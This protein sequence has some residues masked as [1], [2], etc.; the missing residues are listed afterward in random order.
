[1]AES[2]PEGAESVV[3]G[4]AVVKVD[5]KWR[6]KHHLIAEAQLGRPLEPNERVSF[7]DKNRM[8]LDPENIEVK[9]KQST[10]RWKRLRLLRRRILD[11]DAKLLELKAEYQQ[12]LDSAPEKEEEQIERSPQ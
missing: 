5:G 12:L 1:M 4:Y 2:M 10:K 11:M 3:N 9:R 7:R 6:Y 8:N